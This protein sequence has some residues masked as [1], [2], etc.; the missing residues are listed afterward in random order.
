MEYNIYIQLEWLTE[1]W[2][3]KISYSIKILNLNC[4]ISD[5]LLSAK[6]L[7]EILSSQPELARKVSK[8]HKLIVVNIMGKKQTFSQLELSYSFYLLDLPLSWLLNRQIRCIKLLSIKTLT[9]F[10]QS[11]KKIGLK[12]FSLPVLKCLS[13]AYCV[14]THNKGPASVKLEIF[15]GWKCH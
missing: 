15:N 6:A 4:L 9:N 1:I 14:A 2:N 5:F 13:T 12:T 11:M 3:Q 8:L 7:K 10:G